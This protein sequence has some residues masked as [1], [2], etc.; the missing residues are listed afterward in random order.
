MKN[1]K[2]NTNDAG[3]RGVIEVKSKGNSKKRFV[4][5][6]VVMVV[7]VALVL[8]FSL[9]SKKEVKQTGLETNSDETLVNKPSANNSLSSIMK[10]IQLKKERTAQ[11]EKERKESEEKNKEKKEVDVAKEDNAIQQ[12]SASNQQ[13]A[14][15]SGSKNDKDRPLTKRER[16][17]VG[18]TLVKIDSKE[19]AKKQS[20][21]DELQGSDYAD[22]SVN[23]VKNRRYLLSAGT[24]LSCVTRNKIV[25]SYPGINTCQLTKDVWSDNGET[26]L[27][28][29]GSLLIGEQNKAITQGVARVFMN[30]S[31]LKDGNV[32]IR[33][34]GLGT[35]SLG[36][37]GVPAWIDAHL[38]ERYS[39]AIMLSL[40]G[41][42]MDILKNSTTKSNDNSGN[43]TYDN[44][45]SAMQD[46][47]KT[48]LDNTI[49]I[50]PTAVIN[51]G[52]VISVIVPR[53]IDFSP[54]YEVR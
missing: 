35:D 42:G 23:L 47:A 17:L 13:A 2:K 32:N 7:V 37:S 51:Q 29:A 15:S 18:E 10:N 36:A 31:T 11:E 46:M 27:A 38:L 50:A 30:W 12:M 16:Q 25:T 54:V 14:S 5:F 33:I 39:G 41:D 9:M 21:K 19:Q 34:G 8:V 48:T 4:F 53:N 3:N 6:A 1:D 45:S 24:T 43:I 44:T 20:E 26:L 49:N 22:G 52:T 28:R 40:V